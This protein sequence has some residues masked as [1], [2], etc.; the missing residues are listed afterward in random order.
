[1][2]IN[3]G[4]AT[5]PAPRRVLVTAHDAF[6]YFGRAY[7]V[8]VV[9]LQGISTDTEYGLRDVQELVELVV[10]RKI[11]AIFIE[12]SVPPRGI[13]AVLSGARARGHTV[14]LGGALYSDSLDAPHTPAGTYEGMI[15]HNVETIT[16][17]LLGEP[18]RGH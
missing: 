12:T 18:G 15:R 5:I 6:R 2:A 13:Q 16:A 11:P 8:E 9:G 4:W 3:S 14:Q 10:S 7:G 1:M 17:A